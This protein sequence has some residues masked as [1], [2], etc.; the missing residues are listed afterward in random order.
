LF[1]SGEFKTG[2]LFKTN[3]FKKINFEKYN[4]FVGSARV[5][6]AKRLASKLGDVI[7]G[8]RGRSPKA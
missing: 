5:A 2:F 3:N 7:F 1:S 8:I 6:G 4:F